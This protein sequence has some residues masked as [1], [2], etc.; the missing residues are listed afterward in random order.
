MR[1]RVDLGRIGGPGL[2][3]ARSQQEQRCEHRNGD[4]WTGRDE[5]HGG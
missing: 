5:Q 1:L 4:E 2:L 3:A